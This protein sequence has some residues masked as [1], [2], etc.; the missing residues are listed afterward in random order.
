MGQTIGKLRVA[1]SGLFFFWCPACK[2]SHW[3]RTG[4][5]ERPNWT[6]NGDY[7]KPTVKPS[8]D[9]ASRDPKWRCHFFLEDGI[10]K[11]QPDSHHAL[12]GTQVPLPPWD[13]DESE[14]V[15]GLTSKDLF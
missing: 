8:I 7:E 14:F 5:A 15:D 6:W 10:L 12:A 11:Y 13:I 2:H 1:S 3:F 9:V 4:A